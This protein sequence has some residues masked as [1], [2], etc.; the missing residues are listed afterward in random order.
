MPRNKA[1]KGLE[2]EDYRTL[3][4]RIGLRTEID[5]LGLETSE[6]HRSA[7]LLAVD[8]HLAFGG[9]FLESLALVVFLLALADA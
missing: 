2:V 4:P 1:R 7:L 3:A 8:F 9:F 5:N 6:V